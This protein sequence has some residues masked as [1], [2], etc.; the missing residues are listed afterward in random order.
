MNKTRLIFR[1]E[2]LRTIRRA[3]FIILTLSLPVLALLGIGIFHFLS[4]N[5]SPPAQVTRIGYV[6]ELGG[7]DQATTRGTSS[8]C[9]STAPKRP[10]RRCSR[11]IS[12]NT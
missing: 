5:V 8:W 6:D 9:A 3:G 7:L 10:S 2:F 11:R 1:H 12:E 4:R